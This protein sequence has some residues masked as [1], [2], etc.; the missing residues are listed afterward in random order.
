MKNDNTL[1]L[2]LLISLFLFEISNQ[3]HD[4][5]IKKQLNHMQELMTE[6]FA[7]LPDVDFQKEPQ[8]GRIK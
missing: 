8:D 1:V 5:R 4:I 2:G 3:I 7:P 6:Y